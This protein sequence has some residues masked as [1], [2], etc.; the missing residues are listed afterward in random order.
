MCLPTGNQAAIWPFSVTNT[1]SG[2]RRRSITS[3]FALSRALTGFIEGLYLNFD[4]KTGHPALQDK[5][6]R[7][8]L[9]RCTTTADDTSAL[10]R[11]LAAAPVEI[12]I[13]DGGIRSVPALT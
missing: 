7:Q 3:S 9:V 5:R 13:L 8:D 4:A 1:G 6:V 11:M 12:M 2:S 10:R